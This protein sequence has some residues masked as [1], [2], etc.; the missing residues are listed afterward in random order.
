MGKYTICVIITLAVDR[1][2]NQHQNSRFQHIIKV[3][4]TDGFWIDE[5]AKMNVLV[6][7][8]AKSQAEI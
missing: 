7:L 3:I 2:V 6:T 4:C 5:I 8:N 1:C